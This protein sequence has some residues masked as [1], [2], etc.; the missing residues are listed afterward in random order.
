MS[1]ETLEKIKQAIEGYKESTEWEE[2]GK[3]SEVG[4][5][6]AKVT[7]LTNAQSQEVLVIEAG[8]QKIKAVAL[9]LE[10]D[11]V[12]VLILGDG[13]LIKS[14]QTVKRTKQI[15]SMPVGE[16]LL[17]RVIDP[18]GNPI[19]GKGPIF[20]EKD[21][22]VLSFLENDPHG[23]LGRHDRRRDHRGGGASLA[24]IW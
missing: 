15:L 13:S 7:G 22:P 2:I 20:S 16:S 10:E 12:G 11:S 4:D 8:D 1:Q 24:A 19:D 9:N 23:G 6:I 21:K 18:L 5:G 17:G 14:G 3:V